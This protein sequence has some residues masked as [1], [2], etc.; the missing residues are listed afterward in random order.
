[1]AKKKIG[2]NHPEISPAIADKFI[3]DP[4]LPKKFIIPG[5][6]TSVD[7]SKLTEESATA[8]AAKHK[9]IK[10]KPAEPAE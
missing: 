9:W 7:V 3:V 2:G 6:F 4:E 8:L 5:T 1:M 10:P